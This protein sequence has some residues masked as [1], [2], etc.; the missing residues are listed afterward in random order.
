M[1]LL[2]LASF[3]T[4]WLSTLWVIVQVALG[5][6]AVIFIHELGHFVVAKLCGVKCEKFYLGFDIG[7]WKL[8]HF[9]WGETE[10]GIGVLPLGGYVKMLGQDDNPSAAAKEM[11]RAR[12]SGAEAGDQP[13][14]DP[15]SYQAQ[16]VPERMAIISAGVIMNVIFAFVLMFIGFRYV[17][18]NY[19]PCLVTNLVPGEAAWIADIRPRDEIEVL[20]GIARPSFEHNLVT[21][22]A[23]ADL[24]EGVRLTIR[25]PGVEQALE[26]VVKP[27]KSL[28]K[29]RPTIGISP[30]ASTIVEVIQDVRA[31]VAANRATPEFK[32]GDEIIRVNDR[33]IHSHPK[34]ESAL[35]ASA[36]ETVKVTVRR[37]GKELTPPGA[38]PP[39]LTIELPPEPVRT[40]GLTMELG[41]VSAVQENSPAAAAGIRAGDQLVAIDGQPPGDPATL[42]ERLRR[43]AGE[44]IRLSLQRADAKEPVDV[45]A[46]LRPA[47]W[48]E[49]AT[50]EGVAAS[51]PALG[52]AYRIRNRVAEVDPAGPA[53]GL[54][55]GDTIVLAELVAADESRAKVEKTRLGGT[56]IDFDP[57][58]GNVENWPFLLSR[59]QVMMPGT[60][61]R[62]V[63][64]EGREVLAAPAPLEGFYSA[65]RGMWFRYV[66]RVRTADSF[67]DAA[68]LAFHHTRRDLLKVY[69]FL[70]ALAT[71]QLPLTG[72]RGPGTIAVVAG[73]AASA[74]PSYLLVFL[75]MLSANLAVINFLPIPVLDGGHMVFLLWEGIRGKPA[76]EKVAVG[77]Q[78][79]GLAFILLLM[80]FVVSMDVGDLV[81]Y[82][83]RLFG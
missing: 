64:A 78:Y 47:D 61:V 34:L 8:L 65:D 24:D 79:L 71:G 1:H 60:K 21:E 75:A 30:P 12:A 22:V 74:G 17:G 72:L 45:F 11:E 48:V 23:T 39:E 15:R 28:L 33:P 25:R 59:I 53:A 55:P 58:S 57:K 49:T 67:A 70:R 37:G 63:T 50:G 10:Y 43:R 27:R 44:T 73:N 83:T 35:L 19:T 54:K 41:P 81:R 16:S 40:L 9:R 76:K 52:V 38:A 26:K 69:S 80:V 6:G 77:F 4:S 56:K 2:I 36:G 82:L 7:G 31:D 29:E 51:I 62:L 46:T 42:P 13:V 66:T 18:V 32:S 20:N 5:L 14:Y 3:N 68:S